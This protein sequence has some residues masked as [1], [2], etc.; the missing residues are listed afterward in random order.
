MKT[1]NLYLFWQLVVQRLRKQPSL[2][3]RWMTGEHNALSARSR[4][5]TGDFEGALKKAISHLSSRPNDSRIRAFA[6]FCAIELGYLECAKRNME[7]LDITQAPMELVKQIP[8]L[9]YMLK[10]ADNEQGI[11]M[12]VIQFDEMFLSMGCRPVRFREVSK[13]RIFDSLS[14]EDRSCPLPA[15][16]AVEYKP[17]S[18]GPLVSVVMTAFNVENFIAT[19]VWSILKQGY[20]SLELIVVDDCSTDGTT[21]VLR[22]L[23]QEDLRLHVISKARNEGTYVSKNLGLMQAKGKYVA[24][25]DGDD[26]SHPDRIGKS[27]AV[28]EDRSDVSAMTT[29]HVRMTTEG[30]LAVTASGRCTYLS[31]ISLVFRREQVLSRAGFFDSVRVAADTEYIERLK[32]ILGAKSVLAFPWLLNFTRQRPE[33][34]TGDSRF[35]LIRGV[36]GPVR[37]KYRKA[38]MKWHSSIKDGRSGYMPFPLRGRPFEAP[39]V[40]LPG[41]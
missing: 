21:E 23:E 12:A 35:T 11:H 34:L 5:Y 20:R 27:V 31:H 15:S 29:E 25:Q 36:A 14:S 22:Q 10:K 17:L 24:F 18:E 9:K 16:S 33:S 26:W 2:L 13:S 7:L 32:I 28:L 6:V 41:H 39:E 38:Y 19:S 30:D 3:F 4:F 37:M 1:A 8:C 40:M